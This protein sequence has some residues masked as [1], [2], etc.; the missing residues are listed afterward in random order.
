MA[1]RLDFS[2]FRTHYF[3]LITTLLAMLGWVLA[4]IF[5]V[6]ATVQFGHESVR[7]LWFAILFQGFLNVAFIF[8]IATST[9]EPSRFQMSAFASIATVYAVLGVDTGVF[10]GKPTLAA[11]G[12]GYLVLAIVDILWILYFTCEE[13]SLTLHLLNYL[14][15]GGLPAPAPR[16][17]RTRVE[18]VAASHTSRT[19]PNYALGAGV[20]SENMSHEPK[21]HRGSIASIARSVSAV[22]AG[23]KRSG[24]GR[25]ATSRKSLVGSI[26]EEELLERPSVATGKEV[27]PIPD[28]P[29]IPG[30]P[31]APRRPPPVL[32][33]A[34]AAPRVPGTPTL[35]VVVVTPPPPPPTPTPMAPSPVI[36]SIVGA[37]QVVARDTASEFS[38]VLPRAQAL[39]ACS[40]EDPNELSFAKGEILEIEDQEGKWW[41]ARKADGTFGIIPSNYV[42]VLPV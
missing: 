24:T 30:S 6:I 34:G 40:P 1:F 29:R 13:D 3:F 10:S 19:K 7:T 42:T 22:G 15:T 20:G 14:G 26:V 4:F 5:Q 32:P 25:S 35:G 41:Q 16:R 12:A 21:S 27:P 28:I 31:Q 2:P 17:R 9:I 18:S 8:T 38:E 23:L 39:H 36:Q 33:M 37:A 11:M